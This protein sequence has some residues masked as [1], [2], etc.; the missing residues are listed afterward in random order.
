MRRFTTLLLLVP[1]LLAA[2]RPRSDADLRYWLENMV[3]HHHYTVDEIAEA[4][5]LTPPD[6]KAHLK[7]LNISPSSRPKTKKT[8][9]LTVMPYPGGR[10][11]RIGFLD[12]AID[13][14]RGTKI[15]VFLPWP[16]SGY[17]VLDLPEAIFSNLGLTYLAHTHVPTIWTEKNIKLAPIDWTRNTDG[18]LEFERT[19]PNKIAFGAK[20]W[21]RQ[22]S[23]DME[24]WLKNGTNETLTGL[25]TQICVMLKGAPDFNALTNDNKVHDKP[26][27][28]VQSKDGRH[29]I[30][31]AWSHAGRVWSNAP[32]PCMHGDPVFPDCPP[33]QK[34]I[35]RGRLFFHEGPDIQPEFERRRAAGKLLPRP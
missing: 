13:P 23:V 34:K 17:V 33:G 18:T 22:D 6:I 26:T 12:G 3:W 5:G 10:H 1:F 15:S 7:R 27:A 11:P 14:E 31:T 9:T 30:A 2:D 32:V 35:V 28:A 16:D 29:W 20:V 21:P 25:R 19:L 4:T 24:L 8:D